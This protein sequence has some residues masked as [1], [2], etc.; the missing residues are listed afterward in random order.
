MPYVHRDQ[1]LFSPISGINKTLIGWYDNSNAIYNGPYT[2]ID[3][4]VTTNRI[5]DKSGLLNP[6]DLDLS[7]SYV[8]IDPSIRKY[9]LGDGVVYTNLS[10]LHARYTLNGVS[11]FFV[12]APGY[13]VNS[14]RL[15]TLDNY[16]LLSIHTN[17][18]INFGDVTTSSMIVNGNN[19][20]LISGSI[21]YN[22]GLYNIYI[23]G[24]YVDSGNALV[25]QEY[26]M[27]GSQLYIGDFFNIFNTNRLSNINTNIN[28][29]LP[30][31]GS[32]IYPTTLNT[33]NEVLIYNSVLNPNDIQ[34]VNR[35]LVNKWN[36]TTPSTS[37][38]QNISHLIAWYNI[39]NSN[40]LR[41]VTSTSSQIR[42]IQDIGGLSNSIYAQSDRNNSLPAVSSNLLDFRNL[43]TYYLTT[44]FNGTGIIEG[45]T[46]CMVLSAAPY[47]GTNLNGIILSIPPYDIDSGSSI[48]SI[49]NT[50][51]GN[52]YGNLSETILDELSGTNIGVN[53]I[54]DIYVLTIQFQ[55][56]FVNQT[57]Q[58]FINGLPMLVNTYNTY[59]WI[60]NQ[61]KN[62][63]YGGSTYNNS[64]Y[65]CDI[66]LGETIIYKKI[67]GTDELN[68]VH[69]HLFRD[70]NIV[71]P[72][73]SNYYMWFN[74]SVNI[75]NA[76]LP[77]VTSGG[78]S[79]ITNWR[80][81]TVNGGK[82]I[83][84][85][86]YLSGYPFSRSPFIDFDNGSSSYL[87]ARN[88]RSTLSNLS[89]NFAIYIVSSVNIGAINNRGSLLYMESS[90]GS[91][92]NYELIYNNNSNSIFQI[93]NFNKANLSSNVL[94]YTIINN[95]LP[96]VFAIK[97]D[98]TKQSS[99]IS[100]YSIPNTSSNTQV[101]N[102]QTASISFN[103]INTIRVGSNCKNSI[104]DI[105]IYN[106]PLVKNEEVSIIALL[107]NKYAMTTKLQF[108]TDYD[109][110]FDPKNISGNTWTDNTS[111]ITL[112][113]DGFT[114]S[115][116][117][118]GCNSFYLGNA[119]N[120]FYNSTSYFPSYQYSQS[121]SYTYFIVCDNNI[122]SIEANIFGIAS[123]NSTDTYK[124]CTSLRNNNSTTIRLFPTDYYNN[125][126]GS[127]DP[128]MNNEIPQDT[129][130]T[131]LQDSTY[132][133]VNGPYIVCVTY[134]PSSE[135][136]LN[137][138]TK[139]SIYEYNT[140]YS[141]STN[142]FSGE[143]IITIGGFKYYD[144][145]NSIILQNGN[146]FEG[147]I[148]DIIFYPRILSSL[149]ILSVTQ[150]L[151]AKYYSSNGAP[152]NIQISQSI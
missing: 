48:P 62:I 42:L 110:W 77:I 107:Q 75:S 139:G 126:T 87:E 60:F 38:I 53:N 111:N 63:N 93:T 136:P 45:L 120:T 137:I 91:Y 2:Y 1:Q 104:G 51:R 151:E 116:N 26:N 22:S 65:F 21:Q 33:I 46:I 101:I 97:I 82:S 103:N 74:P 6:I 92:M 40:T 145:D 20:I 96:T 30:D 135:F 98:N 67:L 148:G 8:I 144:T 133:K 72:S 37:N 32:N 47:N 24:N 122:A 105:I 35:Y 25:P 142:N 61:M 102:N 18:Y 68:I 88:T 100:F 17:N 84:L 150:Y 85:S 19:A 132:S 81:S 89:S 109:F 14:T 141:M 16:P 117:V 115:V 52:I 15:I 23:N 112:T 90:N 124:L 64:D 9:T 66:S 73:F 113:Y 125:T 55:D 108:P 34:I 106:R 29:L 54:N 94:S 58:I 152:T 12:G 69:N 3:T 4:T 131:T 31:F 36:I 56:S 130:S 59:N 129:Y 44:L 28:R 83:T 49:I 43:N 70:Y 95:I 119:I 140:S 13:T 123:G 86:N 11:F 41:K 71:A 134:N 50:S 80:S 27:T 128:H 5:S 127:I 99:N 114:P 7:G 147:Y 10:Q 57:S 118:I 79:F 121:G 149:E 76:T 146:N 78:K 138:N 143:T 39:T